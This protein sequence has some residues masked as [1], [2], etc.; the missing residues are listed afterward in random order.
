MSTPNKPV[1]KQKENPE[2]P[3]DLRVEWENED[4][5]LENRK[6]SLAED[7]EDT[8]G[9]EQMMSLGVQSL[10]TAMVASGGIGIA[11]MI[12]KALHARAEKA[13]SGPGTPASPEKL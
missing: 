13:D 4:I 8:T 5:E 7:E 12:T 9:R 2:P 1:E 11:S 10:S 3:A 6:P